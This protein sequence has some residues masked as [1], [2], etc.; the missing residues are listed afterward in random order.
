MNFIDYLKDRRKTIGFLIFATISIQILLLVYP[1]H[2]VIR[3]YIF[4]MIPAACILTRFSGANGVWYAFCTTEFVCAG[5]S[6]F[7]YTKEIRK[8]RISIQGKEV[9]S[10][11][12][13][14][15]V[16]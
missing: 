13:T 2:L 14:Q 5:F 12:A 7:I 3:L 16:S 1:M 8:T 10:T 6:A 4:L 15:S 9:A 11:P